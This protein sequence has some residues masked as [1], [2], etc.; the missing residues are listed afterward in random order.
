MLSPNKNIA[1]VIG[2]PGHELRIFRF[3]EM[4]QPRVY[5]LTDGSGNNNTSRIENTIKILNTCGSKLSPVMGYFSDKEIYSIM[6]ENDAASLIILVDKIIEDFEENEIE[7]VFGD[8]IEGFNPT[9]DLCRYII[10]LIVANLEKRKNIVI[11][12]YDFLLD[13]MM[14]DTDSENILSVQ[15]NEEDFNRKYTAASEYTEI[16]YELDQAIFKYGKEPFQKEYLK[17]VNYN[18]DPIKNL[19]EN[20]IPYYEKYAKSKIQDGVYKKVIT[21]NEHLLP[22]INKISTHLNSNY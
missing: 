3:L 12:N 20:E 13:G 17:K 5:V 2:H 19:W 1:L 8:A 11:S 22:L 15:L 21:F 10:N 14:I 6:I 16:A 9:H 7:V 18:D 4:Y